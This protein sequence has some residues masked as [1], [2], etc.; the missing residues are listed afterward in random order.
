MNWDLYVFLLCCMFAIGGLLL[1]GGVIEH[2]RNLRA[3]R[4]AA[5]DR[6]LMGPY[7]PDT[8]TVVIGR[9]PLPPEDLSPGRHR[10]DR[11]HGT[12]TQQLRLVP[13]PGPITQEIDRVRPRLDAEI[14][15]LLGSTT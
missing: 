7:L 15:N 2:Y 10:A 1:L 9:P 4:R 6:R 14:Q 11:A 3:R 5:E 8:P 13:Q 12:L